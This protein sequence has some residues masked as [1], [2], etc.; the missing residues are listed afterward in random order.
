MLFRIIQLIG[1]KARKKEKHKE[2]RPCFS[3]NRHLPYI[4]KSHIMLACEID[5]L[6]L[7]KCTPYV[8]FI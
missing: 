4:L 2:K 6:S 3:V 8:V 5:V 7:Y 1:T